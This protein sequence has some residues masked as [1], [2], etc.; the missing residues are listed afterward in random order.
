[1]DKIDALEETIKNSTHIKT[2]QRNELLKLLAKLRAEVAALSQTD[3]TH[4]ESIAGYTQASAQAALARERDEKRVE[5][6][7]EEL[8]RSVKSFEVSH[9]DLVLT[10]AT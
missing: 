10:V 2:E 5:H 7:I 3:A 4:A 8:K 6:A 1:Q 9:P